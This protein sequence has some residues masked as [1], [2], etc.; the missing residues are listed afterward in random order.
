MSYKC[1]YFY[2]TLFSDSL[3]YVCLAVCC[4]RIDITSPSSST[5]TSID[6]LTIS[7]PWYHKYTNICSLLCIQTLRS[8]VPLWY[9]PPVLRFLNWTSQ[10]KR[11]NILSVQYDTVIHTIF[12]SIRFLFSMLY[13]IRYTDC[14]NLYNI[15]NWVFVDRLARQTSFV[16][17][18]FAFFWHLK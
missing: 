1:A 8:C 15:I 12:Y 4:F 17:I 18:S 3:P 13:A 9:Y 6:T 7:T 2:F 16:V 11:K 14:M 10:S 5:S